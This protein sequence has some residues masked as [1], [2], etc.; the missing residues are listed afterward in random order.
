MAKTKDLI[1]NMAKQ[2]D[3]KVEIKAGGNPNIIT[4][5]GEKYIYDKT[6]T[7]KKDKVEHNDKVLFKKFDEKEYEENFKT[8]LDCLAKKTTTEELLSEIIKDVVPRDL[9]R[10]AKRIKDKKPIKKHKG[11]LGYKFGDT[12]LELFG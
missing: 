2:K 1:K 6:T 11:C 12:Y 8:V 10:L 5:D 4:I 7:Y 9:K 3:K